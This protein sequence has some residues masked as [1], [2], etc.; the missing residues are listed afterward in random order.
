MER[1]KAIVAAATVAGS[2]LAASTAYALTSGIVAGGP[3]DGAG[4]LSP[5]VE[6]PVASDMTPSTT[7]PVASPGGGAVIGQVPGER[8]DDHGDGDDDAFE[9]EDS[10][11]GEHESEEPS[12]YEG[13]DD[14]D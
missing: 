8:P 14:D 2:L 6:A 1:R 13:R 7:A 3:N 10:R 5:V 11:P 9:H 12:H 4:T